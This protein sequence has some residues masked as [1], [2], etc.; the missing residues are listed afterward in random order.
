VTT[1]LGYTNDVSEAFFGIRGK[2]CL[3]LVVIDTFPKMEAK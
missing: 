2:G 3:G 1:V